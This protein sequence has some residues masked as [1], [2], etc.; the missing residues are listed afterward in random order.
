MI[1]LVDRELGLV[2]FLPWFGMDSVPFAT[3][4][5]PILSIGIPVEDGHVLTVSDSEFS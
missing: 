2:A 1:G 3:F 4:G 5:G